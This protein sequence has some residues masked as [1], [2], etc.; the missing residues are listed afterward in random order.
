VTFTYAKAAVANAAAVKATALV[1]GHVRV[2]GRGRIH[3]R[4]LK[5]K[6]AIRAARGRDLHEHIRSGRARATPT[7]T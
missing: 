2:I 1:Q 3:G 4:K 5:L 6:L 7:R